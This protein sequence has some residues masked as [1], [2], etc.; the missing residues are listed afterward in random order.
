MVAN[1][2]LLVA[3]LPAESEAVPL[4]TAK[5]TVTFAMGA[6][7]L[8]ATRVRG[9]AMVAPCPIHRVGDTAARSSVED[10]PATVACCDCGGEYEAGARAI[11]IMLAPV[12]VGVARLED[13]PASSLSTEQEVTPLHTESCNPL[14]AL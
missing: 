6:P 1:P 10:V 9:T 2:K 14:V 5:L 4:V 7:K 12:V 13:S 11:V 3:A 8:S